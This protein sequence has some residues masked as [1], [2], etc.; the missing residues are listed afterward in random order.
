MDINEAV[1]DYWLAPFAQGRALLDNS[2]LRVVVHPDFGERQKMWILARDGGPTLVAVVPEVAEALELESRPLADEADL[3]ERL[4]A[5]HMKPHDPEPLFAIARAEAADMRAESD[6]PN[7]RRLTPEDADAFARF[8][9]RATQYDKEQAQV[10]LS[11]WVAFG[12]FDGEDLMAI[13]SLFA[14]K[15]SRLQDIGILTLPEYRGRGVAR[16][17]VRAACRYAYTQGWDLQYRCELDNVGS[18]ALA[19]ASL[20]RAPPHTLV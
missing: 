3:R 14:W 2:S 13:T 9:E 4:R 5:A 17:L 18:R 11:D 7:I 10:G 20:P 12:A 16:A 6:A 1:D 8:E 15:T 19:R